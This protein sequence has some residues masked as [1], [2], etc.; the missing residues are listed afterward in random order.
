MKRSTQNRGSPELLA[1]ALLARIFRGEYPAGTRLPAERQLAADLGVDRT[2]LRMALKQLQRMNLLV[3]RHG[4]GIEVQD[5]REHGGLEVLAAIFALDDLPL[6]GSFIVEALDFWIEVFSMTA[7]KAVVRMSLDDLRQLERLLDGAVA[8]AGNVDALVVALVELTDELARLSG[9]VIVR[10]LSTS[11]RT[12]RQR[13]I[14]LLP[15]TTDVATPLGQMRRALR[16]AAVSRPPEEDVRRGLYQTL[17]EMTAGLREQLLFGAPAVA[18][19]SPPRR[20]R[21]R[22]KTR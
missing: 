18:R 17:R 7:A 10:M 6:E 13:V 4:S 9:S 21:T 2:T 16:T 3:P 15:A 5:Y 22:R 19:P 11:T 1:D 8:A 12:L 14:R 20:A